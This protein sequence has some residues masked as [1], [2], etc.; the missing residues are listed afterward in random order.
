MSISLHH[1]LG[2]QR[3]EFRILSNIYEGIFYENI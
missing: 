1:I 3:D 2:G